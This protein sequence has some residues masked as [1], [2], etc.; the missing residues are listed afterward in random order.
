MEKTEKTIVSNGTKPEEVKNGWDI[1]H[2]LFFFG[3]EDSADND[4][5]EHFEIVD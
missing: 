4:L 3:N 5:K 2:C 1:P